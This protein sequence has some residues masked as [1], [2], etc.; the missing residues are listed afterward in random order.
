MTRAEPWSVSSEL[1]MFIYKMEWP[2]F[3]V[4]DTGWMTQRYSTHFE[5]A[6]NFGERGTHTSQQGAGV[7]SWTP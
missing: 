7:T 1:L 3:R 6:F 5:L 4:Y 2:C